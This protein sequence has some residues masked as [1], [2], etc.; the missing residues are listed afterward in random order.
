[1]LQISRTTIDRRPPRGPWDAQASAMAPSSLSTTRDFG[2]KA[3]FCASY[4]YGPSGR[5][6]LMSTAFGK[7]GR[8]LPHRG[9]DRPAAMG[10]NDPR[11]RGRIHSFFGVQSDVPI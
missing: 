9:R 8:D 11:F 2:S 6:L 10:E 3:A 5:G 1:M 7:R 4:R